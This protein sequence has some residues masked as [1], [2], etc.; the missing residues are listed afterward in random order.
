[1][2]QLACTSDPR[3]RPPGH[4]I[5]PTIYLNIKAL[6]GTNIHTLMRV[7]LHEMI[8]VYQFNHGLLSQETATLNAH[9]PIFTK[10][11]KALSQQTGS[12]IDVTTW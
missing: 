9:D 3:N 4:F 5:T 12:P 1:M 2:N 7:I 11:A 8:H 10:I 6:R